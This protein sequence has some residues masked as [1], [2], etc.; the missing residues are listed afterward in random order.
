LAS[1]AKDP[2]NPFAV[3]DPLIPIDGRCSETGPFLMVGD[4][5]PKH[6]RTRRLIVEELVEIRA[7]RASGPGG[8][9]VNK[10]STAIELRYPLR[11]AGLAEDHLE[12][13]IKL[14]GDR[15]T[16][17]D[18]LILKAERF[19][20][21][22]LNRDD[23]LNRLSELLEKS[24]IRPRKR[25]ATRPTRASQERRLSAKAGRSQVKAGR[26]RVRED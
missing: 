19:R 14:A 18:V 12:R 1:D 25:V 16:Q 20:S 11:E 15:V 5:P 17:E 3:A 4:L 2:Y 22:L 13:L 21:Q 8:Q 6:V 24:A 7:I 9:N 26:G 23:A 10:V